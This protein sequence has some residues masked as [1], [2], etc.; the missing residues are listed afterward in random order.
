MITKNNYIIVTGRRKEGGGRME[1]INH[2][3][4][5]KTSAYLIFSY[6]IRSSTNKPHA[7]PALIPS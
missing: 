4:N 6:R 5:F 7:R 1:D 3:H 2:I